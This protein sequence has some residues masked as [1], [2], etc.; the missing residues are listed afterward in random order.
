MLCKLLVALSFL[1][2][3][4]TAGLAVPEVDLTKRSSGILSLD[5]DVVRDN[6]TDPVEVVKRDNPYTRSLY[7]RH[8]YYV[9]YLYLGT[10]QQKVA[11]S[12]DSGSSDLWVVDSGS[13]CAH[14]SCQY[15]TYDPSKSTTA[16]KLP[17][18]FSIG[19]VDRS[20]ASGY[21]YTDTVA[22]GTCKNCAKVKNFQFADATQ[23]AGSF[24]ILGLSLIP[25][26]MASNKYPNFIYALK[27][28][29]LI[30]TAGFSVYLNQD[31]ADTG[32][33]LFGGKDLAKIDGPLVT[34]P[35][36]SDDKLSVKLDS[37]DID[38]TNIAITEDVVIDTG[39]TLAMF[40]EKDGDAFFLH[41][42]GGKFNSKI[43]L[44]LCDC[45]ANYAQEFTLNFK[46]ISF[47]ISFES[48]F[49]SDITVQG[50]NYGC[51]FMIGRTPF[52]LLGDVFIQNAYTVFNYDA[53]TISFGHAKYTD[54]LNIVK[55]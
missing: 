48:A 53:K 4:F 47:T 16:K 33:I 49:R 11:V 12:I 37:I 18:F 46:G 32:T 35:I 38:G 26:E 45:D 8:G 40:S 19:Y 55:I 52:N 22:L 10:S 31:S 43:G 51:G 20:G 30:D 54:D 7:N 24:G 39:S 21:Y 44:Y 9:T 42:K 41:Y 14:N 5:F 17:D 36:T 29:G 27:S 2:T 25:G 6:T 1:F 50:V 15:G 34:L 23:V 28:Q 3:A 13:G